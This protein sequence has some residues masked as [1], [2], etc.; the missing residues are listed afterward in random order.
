MDVF[1]AQVSFEN[2]NEFQNIHTLKA[3][4]GLEQSYS[5]DY[6]MQDKGEYYFRIQG[7]DIF[8]IETYSNIQLK[9]NDEAVVSVNPQIVKN[10]L[11]VVINL[12]E[13]ANLA[14]LG[15]DGK[16][17]RSQNLEAAINSIDMSGLGN[18]MYIVRIISDELSEPKYFRIFKQ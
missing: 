8:G 9:R 6:L 18:G 4:N 1:N 10:K 2:S 16:L 3:K 5:T 15:L 11:A 13:N 14:L 17:L 7:V 12:L